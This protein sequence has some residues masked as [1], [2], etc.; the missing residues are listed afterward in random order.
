[1]PQ[2]STT[3]TATISPRRH[4]PPWARVY[5][6]DPTATLHHQ[7]AHSAI[8]APAAP[9]PA[10]VNATASLVV[11]IVSS[12]TAAVH[13]VATVTIRPR[14]ALQA[15]RK[16]TSHRNHVA[17]ASWFVDDDQSMRRG[18]KRQRYVVTPFIRSGY[19]PLQTK[20]KMLQST[21]PSVRQVPVAPTEAESAALQSIFKTCAIS[22]FLV[23]HECTLSRSF[24]RTTPAWKLGGWGRA[25]EGSEEEKRDTYRGYEL[26]L[27]KKKPCKYM[28]LDVEILL[29]KPLNVSKRQLD[30]AAYHVNS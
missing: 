7:P 5:P 3:T 8:T 10:L 28:A 27:R 25:A 14:A 11:V 1:M 16:N 13:A 22:L 12:S 24:P 4:H 6:A 21:Y 19:F 9:A 20:K 29:G 23:K 26:D 15:A 18:D 30:C 17:T 2:R